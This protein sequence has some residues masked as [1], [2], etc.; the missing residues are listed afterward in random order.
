MF[1]KILLPLL[2]LFSCAFCRAAS[3]TPVEML[4]K[5]KGE[6]QV[7][8]KDGVNYAEAVRLSKILKLQTSW[9]GRSGQ[10]NLKGPAGFFCVLRAG[11]QNAAVNGESYKLEAPLLLE[12]GVLYAPISFFNSPKIR[13]YTG[14]Q[15]ELSG[16][17]III[18]KLYDI[19]LSEVKET[20]SSAALI[21]KTKGKVN[22]NKDKRG[23]YF[24]E[25][26]FPKAIIKREETLRPKSSFI[27]RVKIRQTEEGAAL[28]V[29]LKGRGHEWEVFQEGDYIAF[30][31]GESTPKSPLLAYTAAADL[32][33]LEAEEVQSA[34]NISVLEKPS[35]LGEEPSDSVSAENDA[36]ELGDEFFE[37]S[38]KPLQTQ[39]KPATAKNAQPKKTVVNKLVTAKEYEELKKPAPQTGKFRILIDPGHGGK[40]P[41]AVKKGSSK[42]KDL[43][44]AVAKIL[45][46]LLKK[47]KGF[48]VKISRDSDV[49]ITL[50]K[51]ASMAN[52]FKADVF[53]SIHA[54]AAKRASANGFEVY[55]RSDKASD[56]EAAETAALEN[57][58]L[59]YEGKGGGTVSFADLLLKSL[60]TNENINQSSKLAGHIR[61]SVT[62]KSGNLGIKVHQNSAIKQANFYVLRGVN[63]TAVLVEMGYLSNAND[64]KRLNTKSVRQKMAESIRDGIVSYAKAEGRK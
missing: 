17:K 41:G 26:F 55:F 12:D 60:A 13:F 40:D 58:A 16:G 61:N 23:K 37:A 62:K 50:G 31:S 64:R 34:D 20:A 5:N 49:F 21:F 9:F 11:E 29:Q 3:Q 6:V 7:I 63:S 1:K 14:F 8:N 4:G 19:E 39:S 59:Q 27:D 36:V 24:A 54:N 2:L 48:E 47:E 30:A 46:D 28:S 18:E 43:N 53:V 32:K 35:V 22:F 42:E 15:T 44:L 56:A 10:L 33:A 51:R 25:I 52:D 57:E 45:Y 38:A